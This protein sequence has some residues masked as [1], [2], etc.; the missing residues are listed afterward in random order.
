LSVGLIYLVRLL[1]KRSPFD[2]DSTSR[3][4]SPMLAVCADLCATGNDTLLVFAP[5]LLAMIGGGPHILM[6]MPCDMIDG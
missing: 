3:F 1:Q 6:N 5:L 2:Q 4:T